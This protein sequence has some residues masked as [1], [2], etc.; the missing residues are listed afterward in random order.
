MLK[1]MIDK[2][3]SLTTRSL[4]PTV[5]ELDPHN[6]GRKFI[7]DPS[8]GKLIEQ[9]ISFPPRKHT[10]TTLGSLKSAFERYTEDHQPS[11]WVSLTA[12]VVLFADADGDGRL[13]RLT[14]PV[15]PSPLF[16]TV[17]KLPSNAKQL[18]GVI[19]H[20]LKPGEITP[21]N[22]EAAIS[23][24]KWLKASQ[25][26]GEF[27]TLKSTMGREGTA[28]AVPGGDLPPEITIGFEPFP[29]LSA[30]R[31]DAHVEVVLSVAVDPENE[32]IHV[33]PYPGQIEQ[34]KASAVEQLR[35]KLIELLNVGDLDVVFAGTP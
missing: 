1:E 25:A 2:L 12:V 19:R 17:T 21:P 11:V 34:A 28:E 30:D 5:L 27:G 13:Q 9:E 35:A 8:S 33:R 20:D 32:A 6:P 16:E 23:K 10:I 22:F 7:W 18:V 31:L 26:T 14:L 15:T 3:Q 4:T 24:I 29:G